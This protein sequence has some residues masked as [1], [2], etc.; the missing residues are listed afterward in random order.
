MKLETLVGK[1]LCDSICEVRK[2]SEN[3]EEIVFFSKDTPAW[4]GILS[5][6]L[7]P[8]L[9]SA[10]TKDIEDSSVETPSLN[11]D[12]ALKHA[13]SFG[14]IS[15]GQ[16]LYYGTYNSTVILIMLWPWQDKTHV[17]LKKA[18]L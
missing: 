8:A 9:I 1:K 7:G 12:A 17:T 5:E 3:Y 15:K 2:N 11:V 10:E 4:N 6:K 16:T 13:D 18:I 14:G